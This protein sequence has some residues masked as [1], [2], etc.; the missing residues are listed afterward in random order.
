MDTGA[1]TC[2]TP[3]KSNFVGEIEH[4]DFGK[5]ET[6]NKNEPVQIKGRGLVRCLAVDENGKV[7]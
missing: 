2:A 1:S 5:V 4:G 7:A 6:A 3:N